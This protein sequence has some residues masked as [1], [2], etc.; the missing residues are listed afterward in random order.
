MED[1]LASFLYAAAC[2]GIHARKVTY[3]GHQEM[4]Y[5]LYEWV[6]FK[7]PTSN[8]TPWSSESLRYGWMRS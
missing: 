4:M 3:F 8:W 6:L 7:R 2:A 5:E 1:L